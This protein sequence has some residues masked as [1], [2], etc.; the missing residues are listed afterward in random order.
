VKK[1]Q[2]SGRLTAGISAHDA[3]KQELEA[4]LNTH[5]QDMEGEAELAGDGGKEA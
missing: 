2:R 4:V 5:V 3:L 1:L